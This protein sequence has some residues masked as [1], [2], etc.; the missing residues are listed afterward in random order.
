[1]IITIAANTLIARTPVSSYSLLIASIVTRPRPSLLRHYDWFVSLADC[2]GCCQL[3]NAASNSNDWQLRL[4]FITNIPP[5]AP[6]LIVIAPKYRDLL[7]MQKVSRRPPLTIPSPVTTFIHLITP[8]A[9][10]ESASI[11]RLPIYRIP[12]S[13]HFSIVINSKRRPLLSLFHTMPTIFQLQ[14]YYNG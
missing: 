10:I 14:H 12:I 7:L 5:L 2:A 6:T 8:T 1:M 9:S 3:K 4:T 13:L 11:E